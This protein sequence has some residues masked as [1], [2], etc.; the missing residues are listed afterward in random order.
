MIG[1]EHFGVDTKSCLVHG[2][3]RLVATIG[4]KD[5]IVVDTPDAVLVCHKN[6]TQ[7]V[8]GLVEELKNKGKERYL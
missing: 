2:T 4:L 3:E 7:E 6:K 8:K 1:C 5:I